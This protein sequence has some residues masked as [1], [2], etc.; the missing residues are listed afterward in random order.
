MR[1]F[2]YNKGDV[3]IA[4]LIIAVA[5][6]VIYFRVGVVMGDPNP[7]ERLKN[8]FSPIIEYITGDRNADGAE[9]GDDAQGDTEQAAETP[10]QTEPEAGS[11]SSQGQSPAVEEPPVQEET[12]PVQP[13]GNAAEIKITI[14]AG[15]AASTIADKLLEVGAISDKQAFLNEVDAQGAASR[16]KQ[17]TFT[18]PAGSSISDI[19]AILTA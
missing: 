14:N 3:L 4:I 18:I 7:G 15:D 11:D 9:S 5:I 10:A 6:V 8:L 19:I 16:L 2:F 17:G 1:D 12:P 13:P